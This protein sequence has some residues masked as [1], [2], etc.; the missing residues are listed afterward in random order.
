MKNISCFYIISSLKSANLI[1]FCKLLNWIFQNCEFTFKL[2]IFKN[3][4]KSNTQY[5]RIEEMHFS[6]YFIAI[7]FTTQDFI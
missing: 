4:Y 5:K 3:S 2:F 7:Y 6:E 1:K